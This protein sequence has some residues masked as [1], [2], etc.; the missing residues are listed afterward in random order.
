MQTNG[1]TNGMTLE[2]LFALGDIEA[3]RPIERAQYLVKLCESLGLN[4]F[5]QPFALIKF[6]G[7][8][9]PYAKRDAADQLRKLH[10]VSVTIVSRDRTDDLIIVTA[11]ATTPD[12]RTDESIGA[13]SLVGLKGESLANALMK[14][15]TKAKRRVTLSICGLGWLDETEVSDMKGAKPM[16]V[17]EQGDIVEAAPEP[18]SQ[19]DLTKQLSASIDLNKWAG[20]VM[21]DIVNAKSKGAVN[22]VIAQVQAEAK[23]MAAKGSPVPDSLRE[24][25]KEAALARKAELS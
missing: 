2:R 17:T 19:S 24:R 4:P 9:I 13:V 16:R 23:E 12:G 18:A 6:Q 10:S 7:K 3:L 22:E 21:A 25:I 11:R 15:E 5:T 8:T 1:A 14:A 20:D